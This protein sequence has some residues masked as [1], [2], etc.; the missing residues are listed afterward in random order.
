M[1]VSMIMS[2]REM[3]KLNRKKIQYSLRRARPLNTAYFFNTSTYQF[4]IISFLLRPFY[5]G[6]TFTAVS[7]IAVNSTDPFAGLSIEITMSGNVLRNLDS[8]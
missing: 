6:K 7:G 5:L 4:I 1:A 3:M 8:I 2:V